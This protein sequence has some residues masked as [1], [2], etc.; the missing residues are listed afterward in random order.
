MFL[1]NPEYVILN[2]PFSD[3]FGGPYDDWVRKNHL[4]NDNLITYDPYQLENI[5]I[6]NKN[7]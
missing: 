1:E 2:D 6:V 7:S 3:L 4:H 5:L